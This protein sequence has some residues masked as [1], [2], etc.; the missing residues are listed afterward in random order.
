MTCEV[1]ITNGKHAINVFG[2]EL[3]LLLELETLL[4]LVGQSPFLEVEGHVVLGNLAAVT[5]HV[6]PQDEIPF[7][8]M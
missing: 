3:V 7:L 5:F 4:R 8:V 2:T 1:N 6:H